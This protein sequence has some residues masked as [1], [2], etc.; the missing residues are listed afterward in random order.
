MLLMGTANAKH[1][2]AYRSRQVNAGSKRLSLFV[3]RAAALA[4]QQVA[5]REGV[6]QREAIERL[7]RAAV[8]YPLQTGTEDQDERA[9]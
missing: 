6:T 1:Q 8:G 4:I 9:K 7:A 2:A 5:A 3:S